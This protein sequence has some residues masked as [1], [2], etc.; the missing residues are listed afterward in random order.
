MI[1]PRTIDRE[2]RQSIT[3]VA[4]ADPI[5]T[6]NSLSW[7]VASGEVGPGSVGDLCRANGWPVPEWAS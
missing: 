7:L 5:D 2:D 3:D 6:I 4:G 1:I